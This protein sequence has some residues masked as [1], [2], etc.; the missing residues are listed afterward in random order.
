M[1][2]EDVMDLDGTSN[3]YLNN[4][5]DNGWLMIYHYMDDK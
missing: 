3:E 4:I 5:K 1:E 2:D